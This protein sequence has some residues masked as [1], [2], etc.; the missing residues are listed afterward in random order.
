MLPENSTRQYKRGHKTRISETVNEGFT[1]TSETADEPF[2][3]DDAARETPDDP[4]PKEQRE[5]KPK[6]NVKITAGVRRDVEGKI[7]FGFTLGAQMWSMAD[8]VCANAFADNAGEIAKKLTPIICQSPEVVRWL[9]RSG[10]FI[11]W[12]DLA[13]AMWP[14]VQVIFAHHIAKTIGA[15]KPDGGQQRPDV[16]DYVV[17]AA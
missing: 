10:N 5:Y 9:T 6:T 13:M 11:L 1:E 17:Q 3:L 7:A 4:A 12:M 15:E 2:T 8:P 16:N 14:V